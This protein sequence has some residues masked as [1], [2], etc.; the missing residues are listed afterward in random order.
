[1]YGTNCEFLLTISYA[2]HSGSHPACAHCF[3]ERI[4]SSSTLDLTQDS[5]YNTF[6]KEYSIFFDF[7]L[8]ADVVDI[9][10]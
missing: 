7:L 5:R 3:P 6:K 2:R 1:M 8:D 9:K 4:N 10:I